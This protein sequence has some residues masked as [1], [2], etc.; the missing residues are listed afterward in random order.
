[1]RSSRSKYSSSGQRLR[2]A[3]S[4]LN[5]VSLFGNL[6][7][8][9]WFRQTKYTSFQ[10]Q[11]NIYGFKRVNSGKFVAR[12]AVSAQPRTP[13]FD[14]LSSFCALSSIQG[15]DKGAYYH[16]LF[17]R[18][19]AILAHR[20]PRQQIKGNGPRKAINS[21]SAPDFY[22]MEYLPTAAAVPPRAAA[23]DSHVATDRNG[24]D[25]LDVAH[26][27]A[28]LS[29][30]SQVTVKAAE[31][32]DLHRSDFSPCLD[33]SYRAT[34]LYHPHLLLSQTVQ[35]P[36]LS[37]ARS[38]VLQSLAARR[39]AQTN[40]ALTLEYMLQNQRANQCIDVQ[41]LSGSPRWFDFSP[42]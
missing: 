20:I 37:L 5:N 42:P 27:L 33:L 16:P 1:M 26:N 36:Q 32:V 28:L 38:L 25:E 13:F 22:S 3:T 24:A 15:L 4:I 9:R 11:M 35:M 21:H 18:G 40:Q 2:L 14:I 41:P 8:I 19:K 31:R 30:P 34:P 29:Q 17:L 7:S 6:C 12:D 23:E 10:R 39:L